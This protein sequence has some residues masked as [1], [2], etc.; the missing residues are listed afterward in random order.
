MFLILALSR[1]TFTFSCILAAP[2]CV[3]ISV[4]EWTTIPDPI[5]LIPDAHKSPIHLVKN[6]LCYYWNRQQHAVFWKMFYNYTKNCVCFCPPQLGNPCGPDHIKLIVQF[7]PCTNQ[8]SFHDTSVRFDY[9]A[10]KFPVS[11]MFC[12]HSFTNSR[13]NISKDII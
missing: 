3:F 7:Y 13:M 4:H 10:K 11:Q 2:A 5:P 12:K 1:I 9:L 6:L 8:H